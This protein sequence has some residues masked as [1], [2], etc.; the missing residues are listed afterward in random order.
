MPYKNALYFLSTITIPSN[1]LLYPPH[2][3]FAYAYSPMQLNGIPSLTEHV[4]KTKPYLF[5]Y[6]IKSPQLCL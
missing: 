5:P 3:L 6:T 1:S 2:G 4:P